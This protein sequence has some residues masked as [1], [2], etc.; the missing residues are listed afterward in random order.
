M[1]DTHS[2][3][4][5][6]F[7]DLFAHLMG[8]NIVRPFWISPSTLKRSVKHGLGLRLD[9]GMH[10]PTHRQ[11]LGNLKPSSAGRQSEPCVSVHQSRQDARY[12]FR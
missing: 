2:V 3:V 4:V 5:R 10:T 6:Q 7:A 12:S 11:K 1:L 9:S 8:L